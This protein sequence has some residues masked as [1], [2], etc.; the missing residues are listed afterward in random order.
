MDQAAQ[1]TSTPQTTPA[2]QAAAM[3]APTP[4]TQQPAAPNTKKGSH[5][6]LFIIIGIALVLALFGG[7]A[8]LLLQ[9]ESTTQVS[10]VQIQSTTQQYKAPSPTTTQIEGTVEEV[11]AVMIEDNTGDLTEIQSDINQL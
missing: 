7:A 8:Y 11:E 10:E 9:N 5:K 1:S 4:P 2:P 3:P 6:G